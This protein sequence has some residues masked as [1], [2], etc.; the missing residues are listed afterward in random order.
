MNVLAIG[1]HPDD[2]EFMCAGTLLKCKDR[3]DKIFVALTTS[4]NT[5]SNVIP[6]KEETAATREAE[7]LACSE[8]YGAETMFLRFD[9]EGLL[10][11]P[12]TRRAVLNAIRWA[13]PD[14]ILC[15][16]PWDPSPDHGMTGKLVTE[17]LLSVGGQ[18]HD[19]D[20]PP[21]TKQ[22]CVFFYSKDAQLDFPADIYVDITDYMDTKRKLCTMHTSQYE[23][24]AATSG[25][26]DYFER[27]CEIRSRYAGLLA[28]CPYAEGFIAHI[29]LGY[30]PNYK[31]LP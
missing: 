1:A 22:P 15:N 27:A 16:P 18:L 7:Q 17:V 24:I 6:T 31:L 13:D 30:A 5:G 26:D 29:V 19:S 8:Y 11:T 4:G 10:D 2:L 28:D 20:Y 21:M 3:G 12:E 23:W 9:D 14:L 25:S